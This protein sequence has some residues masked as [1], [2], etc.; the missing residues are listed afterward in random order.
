[1]KARPGMAIHRMSRFGSKTESQ[2][3]VKPEKI[4]FYAVFLQKM[5]AKLEKVCYSVKAVA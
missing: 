2:N 5:L 1:M 3:S 4:R